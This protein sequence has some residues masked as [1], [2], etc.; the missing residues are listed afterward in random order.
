MLKWQTDCYHVQAMC[1]NHAPLNIGKAAEMLPETTLVAVA[2]INPRLG[3]LD[4]NLGLHLERAEQAVKLGAEMMVF[5]E[6]SLTGYLL[7]DLTADVAQDIE[8]SKIIK[9]LREA[10]RKIAL[11]VGFVEEG[12]D[13]VYYNTAALFDGGEVKAL[14]RKVYLPTYGMFDEERYFSPGSIFRAFDT[15]F[16]R[17]A[18]LI[19]ED[20]WHPSS[21]YL[22]AQ[23]GAV[24]HFYLANAPER[25]MTL[26]DEI[27]STDIAERM[28]VIS[29]Q[30]YGVYS[31]YAN[32]VGYEDGISFAGR[33]AVVS[34]TGAVPAR[35][36][37][38]N[39]ELL[40]AEID[41]EQV[42][43]ARVFFPLLGDEKLDLVYRELSRIRAQRFKLE[44]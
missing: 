14:H 39:E 2:Q 24:L 40:L 8:K 28:A 29:S 9:R 22:A 6:L 32:R 17:I 36:G 41:P 21:V 44:D 19:C 13:F 16:G 42:R 5:P 7:K 35:A 11:M 4:Y 30:L 23:D 31:I 34:P 33:S 3:D 12:D 26:P 37:S 27:T 18:I 38:Q 43:R 15:R 10:S 20:Y 1:Y 25:G